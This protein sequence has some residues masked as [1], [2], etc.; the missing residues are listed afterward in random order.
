MPLVLALA[1]AAGWSGTARLH[2]WLP[3]AAAVGLALVVIISLADPP[4]VADELT[5]SSGSPGLGSDLATAFAQGFAS[6]VGL[7]YVAAWGIW[8][9]AA[10]AGAAL[11]GTLTRA[12]NTDAGTRR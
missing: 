11:A 10:G 12:A 6:S 2:P 4:S 8:L 5:R 9:A 7:G 3:V 1:F